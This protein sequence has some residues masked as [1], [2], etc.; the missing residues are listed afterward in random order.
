M[1][2]PGFKYSSA[3]PSGFHCSEGG[4]HNLF[5][6]T[7]PSHTPGSAQLRNLGR[8]HAQPLLPEVD[9]ALVPSARD[10]SFHL[11]KAG[12]AHSPHFLWVKTSFPDSRRFCIQVSFF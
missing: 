11:R 5:K 4:Q 12:L 2:E 9:R 8:E 6:F 1:S 7:C 10:F 3:A